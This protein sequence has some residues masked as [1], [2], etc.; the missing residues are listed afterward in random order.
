MSFML[1]LIAFL[2]VLV[3]FTRSA[4]GIAVSVS[5]QILS[6]L[7][8]VCVLHLGNVSVI[9]VVKTFLCIDPAIL[10]R[11]RV[12]AVGLER[13]LMRVD[14]RVF[15]SRKVVVVRLFKTLSNVAGVGS[16]RFGIWSWRLRSIGF[17]LWVG[18]SL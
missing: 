5:H 16:S 7:V 1:I 2:H 11:A 4:H 14:L 10:H 6:I 13:P 3:C 18:H 12:I 15:E 17:L 8:A 9:Q